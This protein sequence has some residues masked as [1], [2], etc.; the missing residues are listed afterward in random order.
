M[1]RKID[2]KRCARRIEVPRADRSAPCFAVLQ[3]LLAIPD[4]LIPTILKCPSANPRGDNQ[5]ITGDFAASKKRRLDSFQQ[6][7]VS[8]T[9]RPER[10]AKDYRRNDQKRREEIGVHM[11]LQGDARPLLKLHGDLLLTVGGVHFL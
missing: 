11:L 9:K 10:N 2:L 7:S 3:Q 6:D 1:Q 4:E 8:A 5:L